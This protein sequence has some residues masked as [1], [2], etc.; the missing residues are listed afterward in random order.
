MPVVLQRTRTGDDRR[1]GR[2]QRKPGGSRDDFSR[3]MVDTTTGEAP[4]DYIM[5]LQVNRFSRSLEEP[6]LWKDKLSANGVQVVS[7]TERGFGE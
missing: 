4:F 5:V 6:A 1:I 2:R 7:V 3:M